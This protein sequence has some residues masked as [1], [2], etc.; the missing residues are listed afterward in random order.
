MQ[1][2][3]SAIKARASN[4]LARHLNAMPLVLSGN[5][6]MVSF[7]FDDIPDAA[8]TIAAPMIEEYGI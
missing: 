7:A 1:S 5:D 8:A 6:P 4:R 3:W 2:D